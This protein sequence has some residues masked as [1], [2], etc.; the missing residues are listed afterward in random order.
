M[1]G[2]VFDIQ[3]F[4]V[5]DGPGSRVTV[6]LKGCQMR[7]AWCHNPEGLSPKPQ[8]MKKTSQCVGCGRCKVKC[9]HPEC[10]PFGVCVHACPK[11]LLS[12]LGREWEARELAEHLNAYEPMLSDGGV[13]F[14]GGEPLMQGEFVIAV[15]EKLWIHKAIQTS[16][17]ADSDLFKRVISRMDYVLMDMKLADNEE[18]KKYTGVGNEKILKNYQILLKSGI[19]HVI[20]VPLIPGVTDTKKNLEKIAERTRNSHVELMRYNPLTAAKYAMIG[21]K[22]EFQPEVPSEV[23]ISVFN[24]ASFI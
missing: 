12:V 19:P 10:Q 18:H 11:G 16:G 5:H 3:E 4:T 20:R 23:D 7:C 8:L 21:K 24:S 6:F 2:T 17:Y 15:A 14:S 1:K 9:D 13:T 22:F